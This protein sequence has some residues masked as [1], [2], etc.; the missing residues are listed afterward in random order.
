[1][2]KA[3]C[4]AQQLQSPMRATTRLIVIRREAQLGRS[5]VVILIESQKGI[6]AISE[7]EKIVGPGSSKQYKNQLR[8]AFFIIITVAY[9]NCS[10]RTCEV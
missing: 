8:G 1:M 2:R 4:A 9:R 3:M 6:R 7:H 10:K 5:L